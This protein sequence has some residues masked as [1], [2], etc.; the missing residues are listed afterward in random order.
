MRA[1]FVNMSVINQPHHLVPTLTHTYPSWVGVYAFGS[2][3]ESPVNLGGVAMAA[4]SDVAGPVHPQATSTDGMKGGVIFNVSSEDQAK[5][6]EQAGAVAVVVHYRPSVGLN[7]PLKRSA[8]RMMDPRLLTDIKKV[9]N[10]PVI[11][12]VR[13]GHFVEGQ[14]MEAA[15]AD[16]LDE[17]EHIPRADSTHYCVKHKFAVPFICGISDMRTALCRIAEGATMVHLEVQ[18]PLNTCWQS[19]RDTSHVLVCS[20]Y[21][22]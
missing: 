1:L 6:A 11:A 22:I 19:R 14:V 18:E 20:A 3:A 10:I 13:I 15:G 12:R 5:I 21:F 2:G 9:V 16:F 7:N 4:T 17:S 8:N